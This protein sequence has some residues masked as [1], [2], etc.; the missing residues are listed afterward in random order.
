MV[1][2]LC[3]PWSNFHGSKDFLVLFTFVRSCFE[4]RCSALLFSSRLPVYQLVS[5]GQID[6]PGQFTPLIKKLFDQV[7]DVQKWPAFD[8]LGR[9]PIS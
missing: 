4:S 5:F 3:W 1:S 8:V 2:L 6:F 9:L 7:H